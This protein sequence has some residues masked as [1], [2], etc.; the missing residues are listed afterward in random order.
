MA[1]QSVTELKQEALDLGLSGNLISNYVFERQK[2]FREERAAKR[3][4]EKLKFEEE[5]LKFEE[6]EKIRQHELQLAAAQATG[7]T[8]PSSESHLQKLL[9]KNTK[10]PTFKDG[11]DISSYFC[12]FERIC[13]M[14]SIPQTAYAVTLG[15]L[16]SGRAVDVYASLSVEVTKDYDRLKAALLLAYNKT[17]DSYRFEFKN[18][19]IKRDETYQQYYESLARKFDYWVDSVKVAHSYESLK[20]FVIIDQ[21]MSTI[22]SELRLYVKERSPASTDELLHLCD[23]WTTARKKYH[24]ERQPTNPKQPTLVGSGTKQPTLPGPENTSS[25][26]SGSTA[27]ALQSAE[28]AHIICHYCK[29]PGHYK[30]SCP[31][32]AKTTPF[33]ASKVQ[34]CWDQ[35]E[36]GQWDLMIPGT[37]NGINVSTILLD[38][39]C[40]CII[41]SDKILPDIDTA[42]CRKRTVYDYLGRKDEFPVTK[43]YIKCKYFDGWADV[44]IAPLK[45]ASVLL[46]GIKP[47]EICNPTGN[48]VVQAV[49]LRPRPPS[50]P[51]VSGTAWD[52]CL[53]EGTHSTSANQ[54]S[55][56]AMT[57]KAQKGSRKP[58]IS[59]PIIPTDITRDDMILLQKSC[60]TLANI[61]KNVIENST[62]KTRDGFEYK[63]L[64]IDQLI[65]RVCTESKFENQL[66]LKSLVL[67]QKCRNKVLS[68]AH[69]SVLAGH[70]SHKKTKAKIF[71]HF[72]WPGASTDI[73]N[74][75]KSCDKCQRLNMRCQPP[76]ALTI[77]PV[78]SEPF[79]RVNIDLVGPLDPPSSNGHRYILTMIDMATNFPDAY[80][81]RDIDTVSVCEALVEIFSRVGIPKE[82]LSDNGV[83][84]KAQL[85]QQMHKMLGVKPIFTTVYHP[86]TS[87]KIERMHSTM[88]A[89]LRKLCEDKPKT[90]NRYIPCVMFALREMPSDYTGFSPFELLY[91]RQARGPLAVLSDLWL[92]NSA[93]DERNLYQYV[94]ELQEKLQSSAD[95]AKKF[96]ATSKE[97]YKKYFDKKAVKN[98]SIKEGDEVLL[99]LPDSKKKLL[100]AWKGPYKVLTKKN[101]VNYE[102]L[103]DGGKK[104]YHANLLKKY[105][106][107]A[108]EKNASAPDKNPPTE[109]KGTFAVA[110][111]CVISD[112]DDEL[113]PS[114]E[115]QL[116]KIPEFVAEAEPLICSELQDEEKAAIKAVCN[117]PVFSPIPGLTRTVQ[118]EIH[119]ETAEPVRGKSYPVPV[120]LQIDFQKEVDKLLEMN[121]IQ[122]SNSPYSFPVVMVKKPDNSYRMTIDYRR[123]NDVTV[124]D[125]E[126]ACNVEEDLH[127][128]TGCNFFSELDCTKAYYQIAMA[129]SSMAYTAFPSHRGL[130]EFRRM[131]FGV[132][133]ACATYVRLM[134]IVLADL[135]DVSFYFDNIIIFTKN[136]EDHLQAIKSVL[137]RLKEHGLTAQPA[138]CKFGFKSLDYLGFAVSGSEI[139]TQPA[140]TE[141]IMKIQPPQTKKQLRSFLGLASFYRKFVPNLASH[142]A[143]L[144][145]LLKK[146]VKQ[147][148]KFSKEELTDFENIKVMLTSHPILRLPDCSKPFVLRTDSSGTALGA[149]L[150]QYSDDQPFPVAYASRKLS[151]AEKNYSTIDRECLAIIFGITKFRFY[152][153]G[154]KFILEVDHQPLTHLNKFKGDNS[155]IMRW[156]LCLQ[157]YDYKISYIKGSMNH[158]ADLLSRP[159]E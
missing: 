43:C 33:G 125:A 67:P 19:R 89:C 60:P 155:R 123:L 76:V 100:M 71:A 88:K 58:L 20:E 98:K 39:G 12:R 77:T 108:S 157:S 32:K 145:E 116:C 55:T 132:K 82:I 150:L 45:F 106:R 118:H 142:T 147:P 46:G 129:E 18:H 158:G 7:S 50:E 10:L 1:E 66:G 115:S 62:V 96:T 126:P 99:F 112:F 41:V 40:D 17:P 101:N 27:A 94:I 73:R 53:A 37:V 42:N 6:R 120:H 105:F 26:Q 35:A 22:P 103:Q 65:F 47:S 148:I 143:S 117:D 119:L 159:N 154:K 74:F 14:L 113:C 29:K 95:L 135:K 149:I 75:C 133:N 114:D 78:I 24:S 11:D 9:A 111:H 107:R 69:E 134:R 152:L 52:S 51:T 3:D 121:V 110:Q 146:D 127:K 21:V 28:L 31:S 72:F 34:F 144:T 8:A 151:K 153:I 68:L 136:F 86:Q 109:L 38:T 57:G 128:F 4:L 156:A 81:L 91:G 130:M 137:A 54:V 141:A 49:A 85:M 102:I 122:P 97:Q 139:L 87:G 30:S 84:F 56:R 5:K 92:E 70:F 36:S 90:W 131:P 79:A 44:V 59:P 23:A 140:K 61:R 138:K 124:S 16:L 13:Q 48:E 63:F 2:I 83:Q 25:V 93:E 15:T 64:E 104:L 80:P